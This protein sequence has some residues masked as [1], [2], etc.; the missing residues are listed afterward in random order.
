MAKGTVWSPTQ[1]PSPNGST[2]AWLFPVT[3][4]MLHLPAMSPGGDQLVHGQGHCPHP[5]SHDHVKATCMCL[6]SVTLTC[7]ALAHHV[8]VAINWCMAKGTVPIPGA[9]TVEQSKQ[10]GN[11]R[12]L[13]CRA[14]PPPFA[15]LQVAINWCMAKGTVPIPGAKSVEQAK[16]NLGALG[17]RLSSNE[18]AALDDAAA[19]VPRPMIQNIFQTK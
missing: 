2:W 9:K 11:L 3:S 1:E 18:V 13:N 17:W 10:T 6:L 7:T 8:Q 16:E 19:E 15:L 14:C 12:V 4:Y 5:R